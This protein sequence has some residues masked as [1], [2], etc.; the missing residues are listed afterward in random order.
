M[1]EPEIELPTLTLKPTRELVE[2]KGI[3]FRVWAGKDAHGVEVRCFVAAVVTELDA[4]LRG[5]EHLVEQRR[6]LHL[7]DRELAQ[8][9]AA[10]TRTGLRRQTL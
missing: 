7:D 4:R 1:N 2:L 6:P 5:S 8:L 9:E 10:C 3:P